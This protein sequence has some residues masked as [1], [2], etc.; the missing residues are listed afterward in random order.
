MEQRPDP[1]EYVELS[2]ADT[3]DTTSSF[4]FE[5]NEQVMLPDPHDDPPHRH[6]FHEIIFVL[7]G[8]GRH[9]IDGERAEL[10]P[11][12][13]SLIRGRGSPRFATAC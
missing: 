7:R 2:Y 4:W 8:S 1:I 3:R 13:V 9:T 5:R 10:A 6:N 11:Y 12:S